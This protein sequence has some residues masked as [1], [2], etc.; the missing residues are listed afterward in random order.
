MREHIEGIKLDGDKMELE[1]ERSFNFIDQLQN[2]AQS[3]SSQTYNIIKTTATN[4]S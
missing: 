1:M 4:V 3:L 2:M